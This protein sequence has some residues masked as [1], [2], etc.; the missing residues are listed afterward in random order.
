MLNL[1]RGGYI[2]LLKK[3]IPSIQ[4]IL[5]LLLQKIVQDMGGINEME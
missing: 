4:I 2:M 1:F 5:T 3:E